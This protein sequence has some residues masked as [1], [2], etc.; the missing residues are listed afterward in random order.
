MRLAL[1]LAC[2]ACTDPVAPPP[3]GELPEERVWADTIR[4]GDVVV[5]V[6]GTGSFTGLGA[7]IEAEIDPANPTE[8]PLFD[9][10]EYLINVDPLEGAVA[11]TRRAGLDANQVT[12]A[13][14]GAGI[15]KVAA[16]RY[17]SADGQVV[18]IDVIEGRSACSDGGPA[19]N[20]LNYNQGNADKDGRD[21]YKHGQDYLAAG[22]PDR[23]VILVSHSWGGVVAE[24]VASNLA[25]FEHDH[26]PLGGNLTFVVAAGVPGYVPGFTTFGD[27]FRTVESK[28]D[29]V[30]S[31]VKSFEVNRADDPVHALNPLRTGAG[32]HYIIMFGEQYV[33]WYGVT[34]DELSCA[35]IPGI[36]PAP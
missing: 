15:T 11:A 34:T 23:N 36:C 18:T 22:S 5:I 10:R 6:P 7:L 26:G 17:K 25:T 35:G 21:L 33:G 1:L 16:F 9:A 29:G 3:P 13:M 12:Y 2:A 20:I 30:A 31:A 4:P 8:P 32:H 27:G 28:A 24:Y 14:W 19:D